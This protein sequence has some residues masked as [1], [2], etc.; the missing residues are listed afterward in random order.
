[1]DQVL[2]LATAAAALAVIAATLSI[3]RR[4]RLRTPHDSP[5][6]ASTEG[7]VR[8]PTCGMGNP[9]IERNCIACGASLS[10]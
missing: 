4:E 10:G 7:S 2:I 5:F 1:M 6:A 3:L 8:C 9:N